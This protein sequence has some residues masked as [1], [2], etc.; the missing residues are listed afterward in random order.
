M[1]IGGEK[2]SGRKFVGEIDDICVYSKTLTLAEIT[3][4]FNAGKRSHR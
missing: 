2:A 3:R 4:N 1:W